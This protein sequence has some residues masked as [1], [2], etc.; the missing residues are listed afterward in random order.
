VNFCPTGDH[1][2]AK[3]HV[4]WSKGGLIVD[5]FRGL[6]VDAHVAVVAVVPWLPWSPV[7]GADRRAWG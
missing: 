2:R 1:G 6:I 3:H 4:D 7:Q 5:K